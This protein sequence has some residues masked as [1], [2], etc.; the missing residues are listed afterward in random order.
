MQSEED[1]EKYRQ[2]LSELKAKLPQADEE[3]QAAEKEKSEVT[4][5]YQ[6]YLQ[7][8]QTDYDYILQKLKREKEELELA[9]REVREDRAEESRE[10][11]AKQNYAR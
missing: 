5:H 6:I 4:A 3:L 10:Q 11:T 7:Q 9:E 2:E 1:I 8:M